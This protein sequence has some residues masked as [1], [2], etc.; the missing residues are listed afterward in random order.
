VRPPEF[1]TAATWSDA[2]E[3]GRYFLAHALAAFDLMG[4]DQGLADARTIWTWIERQKLAEFTAR[5][6][7]VAN[8]AAVRTSER[9]DAAL[10]VLADHGFVREAVREKR[11]GRPS[12]RYEISPLLPRNSKTHRNGT[13]AGGSV[14]YGISGREPQKSA[15]VPR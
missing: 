13:Q 2:I 11:V 1:M 8:R 4:T 14:D 12:R 6:A 5:D 3:I 10:A 7:R 9:V 15:D